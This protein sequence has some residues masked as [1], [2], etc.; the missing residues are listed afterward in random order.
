MEPAITNLVRGVRLLEKADWNVDDGVQRILTEVMLACRRWAKCHGPTRPE[1]RYIWAAI[2]RARRKLYRGVARACSRATIHTT[3]EDG[4]VLA[5]VCPAPR[6]DRV[7]EERV[8][9]RMYVEVTAGLFAA[10]DDEDAEL[11]RLYAEGLKPKEIAAQVGRPGDNVAVSQRLYMLRARA[12]EQLARLGIVSLEDLHD[13][14]ES[15]FDAHHA[16]A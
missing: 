15:P 6:P 8:R 11:L 2:H 1:E 14:R 9:Q 3:S 16:P 7:V 5:P 13:L 4:D 12:R 10:L